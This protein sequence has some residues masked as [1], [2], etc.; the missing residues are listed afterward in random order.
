MFLF[1]ILLS[2]T[3]PFTILCAPYKDTNN[4]ADNNLQRR[5]IQ[6][7]DVSQIF[8]ALDAKT[9]TKTVTVTAG[10]LEDFNIHGPR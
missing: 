3:L 2:A 1:A 5:G 7:I 8:N 10:K 4:L 6:T 9:V